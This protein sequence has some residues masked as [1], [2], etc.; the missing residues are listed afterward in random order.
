M[1]ESQELSV[2][3]IRSG[4]RDHRNPIVAKSNLVHLEG[5]WSE[6][7]ATAPC[8]ALVREVEGS[9]DPMSFVRSR[10]ALLDDPMGLLEH[11][12]QCVYRGCR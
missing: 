5:S 3:G 4:S 2:T 8:G 10:L 7:A 1:V 9:L 11:E 6:R 12:L